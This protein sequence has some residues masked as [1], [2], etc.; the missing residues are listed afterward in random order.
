MKSSLL[1]FSSLVLSSGDA[2][3]R[4]EGSLEVLWRLSPAAPRVDEDRMNFL[5]V[6]AWGG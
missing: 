1:V 5:I 3:L 6:K 4:V 2:E